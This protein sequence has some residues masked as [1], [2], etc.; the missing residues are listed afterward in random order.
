MG[1]S[2]HTFRRRGNISWWRNEYS[3]D[4]QT[5]AR[6][7]AFPPQAVLG[8]CFSTGS[9]MV[10]QLRVTPVYGRPVYRRSRRPVNGQSLK[11]VIAVNCVHG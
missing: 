2:K 10:F 11:A 9:P 8:P 1:Y 6:L 5:H 4:G 3:K 7:R